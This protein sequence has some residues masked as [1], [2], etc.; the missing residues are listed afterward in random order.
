MNNLSEIIRNK[1][2]QQITQVYYKIGDKRG[3]ECRT[4]DIDD[5]YCNICKTLIGEKCVN[6]DKHY[7]NMCQMKN[8]SNIILKC[9]FDDECNFGGWCHKCGYYILHE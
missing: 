5:I 6:F 9:I 1:N 8:K 3:Y 4:S 2:I 7:C